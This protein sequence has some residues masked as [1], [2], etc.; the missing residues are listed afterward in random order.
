M[1]YLMQFSDYSIENSIESFVESL[2]EL[3]ILFELLSPTVSKYFEN[4][5][6]KTNNTKQI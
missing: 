1:D 5:F 3:K 2:E 4:A 6:I